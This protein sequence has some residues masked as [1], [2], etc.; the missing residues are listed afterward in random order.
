[1][2]YLGIDWLAML[3]TFSGIYLLGNKQRNGFIAMM[4]GNTS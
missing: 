2:N 4:L 3:L 1:M